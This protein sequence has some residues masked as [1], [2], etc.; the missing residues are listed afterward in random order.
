MK[1]NED[2]ASAWFFWITAGVFWFLGVFCSGCALAVWE[3]LG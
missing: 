3:L 1:L 2:N